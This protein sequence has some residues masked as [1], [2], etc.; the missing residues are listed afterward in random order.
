MN[1]YDVMR[2]WDR[3]TGNGIRSNEELDAAVPATLESVDYGEWK[4]R[5]EAAD[6][7]A[8][9]KGMRAWGLPVD[10]LG[11]FEMDSEITT[12]ERDY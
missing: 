5:L 4:S 9:I 3:V 10:A 7:K 6:I 1:A 2:E 11:S 8:I 12:V